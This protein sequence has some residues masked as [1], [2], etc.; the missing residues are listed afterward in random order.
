MQNN[1]IIFLVNIL[2]YPQV[3]KYDEQIVFRIKVYLVENH[4][5]RPQRHRST[6][7]SITGQ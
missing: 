4:W 5:S 3:A 2:I 7:D 6:Q 1:L